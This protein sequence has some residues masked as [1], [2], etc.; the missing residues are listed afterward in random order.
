[1]RILFLLSLFF[2]PTA[3]AIPPP[4]IVINLFQAVAQGLGIVLASVCVFWFSAKDQVTL[5]RKVYPKKF[6]FGCISAVV[7]ILSIVFWYVL[8][9]PKAQQDAS[10]YLSIE[11]VIALEENTRL[12]G[13]KFDLLQDMRNNI[14][15]YR[16]D[17]NLPQ[18]PYPVLKSYAPQ[19]LF[20]KLEK[21]PNSIIFFDVREENEWKQFGLNGKTIHHRYGDL[22][23]DILPDV[24]KDA[25]LVVLCYSGIRGYLSAS[26]LAHHGFKNVSYIQGGLGEWHKKRLP[27]YGSQNFVFLKDSSP[28]LF[29]TNIEDLEG[30]ILS[31]SEY[32]QEHA[33]NLPEK[34]NFFDIE[35]MSFDQIQKKLEQIPPQSEVSIVCYSESSCFDAVNILYLLRPQKIQLKAIYN[36]S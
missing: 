17:L 3:Y 16:K 7:V 36:P 35:T 25:P 9:L 6:W 8:D 30:E 15:A 34:T 13:W 21:E 26:I 1:M 28:D 29:V 24:S 33:E 14:S 18:I 5:W 2:V 31:F 4:D 19:A 20:T 27:F 22:V 23:N 11:Q 32:T 12:Q 10:E